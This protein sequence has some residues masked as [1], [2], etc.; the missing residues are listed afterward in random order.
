[1]DFG[2]LDFTTLEKR[3]HF[4]E[5]EVRLNRRLAPGIYLRV[6]K[7]TEQ[8]GTYRVGGR[9]RAVE[10]AVKMRR[11]PDE[12]IL[13]NRLAAGTADAATIGKVARA[14]AAFHEKAERGGRIAGFG[15]PEAIGRNA[16]ENFAQTADFIGKT[17]PR[18]HYDE[19]K[20]Y[21]GSFLR[22]NAAL[23]ERRA[24]NGFVRDCHGDLHTE[25]IS[26]NKRVD[27]FDCIEFNERFRFSDVVAD[28]AFLSMDLDY[29]NR[30][31]L[32]TAFDTAYF[33]ATG[34]TEGRTLLD[35]YRC[36]RAYVRGKVEGFKSVEDE[37]GPEDRSLAEFRA[38]YHFHL[39]RLYAG[40]GFRPTLVVVR[41]LSGTGKS[42]LAAFQAHGVRPPEL[43]RHKERARR[44]AP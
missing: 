5:E 41:G 35:F 40:R 44:P 6:V 33:E 10:Y 31:D 16:A 39:S 38:R 18:A 27:V 42:T 28:A 29:H 9:G 32:A 1:M 15:S 17:I 20:E 36:Y 26:V 11:I 14:V 19:I 7:V 12:S 30:H 21:T 22:K 3:R 23:L 4:C 25:H 2:F 13:E 43:R 34:D 24:A 37:V 8:D